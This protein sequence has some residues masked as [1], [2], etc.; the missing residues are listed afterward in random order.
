MLHDD[1]AFQKRGRLG[2]VPKGCKAEDAGG[3]RVGQ[4]RAVRPEIERSR[5]VG[6][7]AWVAALGQC[8]SVTCAAGATAPLGPV[9]AL[10]NL[11]RTHTITLALAPLAAP[12]LSVYS[13]PMM[14][15]S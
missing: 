9:R 14:H 6:R 5:P 10:S 2:A 11:R 12:N 8:M 13:F 15:F 3:S 1:I 7:E 4:V